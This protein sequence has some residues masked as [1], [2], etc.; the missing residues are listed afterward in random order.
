MHLLA[1]W[2]NHGHARQATGEGICYGILVSAISLGIIDAIF[3]LRTSA[4]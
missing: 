4:Q 1:H 3:Y 2:N